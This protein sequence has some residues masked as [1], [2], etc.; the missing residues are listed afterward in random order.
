[1]RHDFDHVDEI[2]DLFEQNDTDGNDAIDFAEFEAL[3]L[4]LDPNMPRAA[5]EV[6][7]RATD[8]DHD[9]RIDLAEFLDW[10]MTD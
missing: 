9:G 3:V 5:L 7:F 2:V 4:E 6:G 10:W 8:T 1:M